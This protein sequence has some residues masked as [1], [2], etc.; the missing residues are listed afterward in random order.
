MRDSLC[1]LLEMEKIPCRMFASAHD[2]L[3]FHVQSQP[4]CILLDVRMPGM[5]GIELLENLKEQ[6]LQMPVIIITGH[7]D[8]ALAVRAMKRGAFDF[9]EKPFKAEDLLD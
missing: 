7:G 4:G 5:D 2:F 9:I 8:V 3:E 1:C 6:R